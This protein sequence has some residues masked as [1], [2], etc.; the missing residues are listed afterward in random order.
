MNVTAGDKTVWQA[1]GFWTLKNLKF[2]VLLIVEKIMFFK[3][4]ICAAFL[5]SLFFMSQAAWADSGRDIMQRVYKQ[6]DIFPQSEAQVRL[7][8]VDGKG[9]ERERFFNL[10]SKGD[11]AFKRSLVKFFKPANVK[12]VGLASETDLGTNGKQQWVYFPSLKS[13]KKLSSSEQDGSFMGS[14]F[15]YSD[16]AG[17]TLDQD[18]HKVFQQNDKF[19]VIE[20]VPHNK[21]DAYSKYYTTVDKATNIVRSVTFY[22]KGGDK[23]KTLSN[24]KVIKVQGELM[25]SNSV[26]SNHKS[27][28]SSTMERS[29]I[30]VDVNFS[31]NDVGLKGLK[32]N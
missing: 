14:D 1:R 19:Y 13:V 21:A 30:K 11:S 27:G 29:S 16:I 5:A 31:N 15:S 8:V 23:L 2:K 22:D 4:K 9:R 20:S 28:G 10:R 25:V 26:M 3:V 7:I 17:R 12:G 18:T 24:R 32:A 6:A